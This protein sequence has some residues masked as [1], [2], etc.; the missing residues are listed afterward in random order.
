MDREKIKKLTPYQD[1]NNLLAD[2]TE[3]VKNI[4]GE[5]VVGL[6]LSDSL[7]YGDFVP[8]RSDIDLHAVVRRPLKD[9]ELESVERL[10]KDLNENYLGWKGRLECSYIPLE[11]LQETSPPKTP[12]PWWGF[13]RLYAEAPAG[14]EWIIVSHRYASLTRLLKVFIRLSVKHWQV[15]SRN[16]IGVNRVN[17]L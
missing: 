17:Y 8:E 14:N 12:R 1:I 5:N 6:Y 3:G 4:L 13:N 11:L 9:N 2:W 15:E 16:K 10:H 7:T